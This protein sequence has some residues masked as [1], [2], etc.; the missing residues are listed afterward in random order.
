MRRAM[1]LSVGILVTLLS[2]VV[3]ATVR[4][5]GEQP[6]SVGQLAVLLAHRRA[7]VISHAVAPQARTKLSTAR[8][9]SAWDVVTQTAGP[10]QAVTRT[11]VV[12]EAGGARDEIEVLR[13]S[14][15]YVGTL[16]AHR[17]GRT[18]TA[19]VLFGGT[20]NP[21]LT[22]A[23]AQYARDL[24]GGR[25]GPVRAKFDPQMSA[26]LSLEQFTVDTAEATVGLHQPAQVAAQVAAPE[27]GY[28]VVE[29][30]V[31]FADGSGGSRRHSALTGPLPGSTSGLCSR[32]N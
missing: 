10:L 29:T 17:V 11:V 8:L 1:A 5:G 24:V 9:Q 12:R 2:G 4:A 21:V 19:L 27:S 3:A 31:V 23:A 7:A 16:S 14:G 20:A 22:T 6:A 26:V 30:Y 28:T 18:I 13:F 32:C 25:L 15:D